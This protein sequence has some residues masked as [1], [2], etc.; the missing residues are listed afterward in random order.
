MTFEKNGILLF[1]IN[2]FSISLNNENFNFRETSGNNEVIPMNIP[3]ITANTNPSTR[4][5]ITE[6]GQAPG[7]EDVL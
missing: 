4:S 3:V 7:N 1:L 2:Y 6:E 5:K